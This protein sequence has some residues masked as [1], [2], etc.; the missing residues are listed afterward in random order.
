MQ[1]RCPS[2]HSRTSAIFVGFTGRIGAGKTS[3]AKYLSSQYGFQYVRYSQILQKWLSPGPVDRDNLRKLGSDVMAGGQQLELNRRLI[4]E[5]DPNRSAAI[6]GVRHPIDFE[7]LSDVFGDSFRLIFLE[8]R[9]EVR[10]DRLRSRFS[11]LT[12]FRAA[13]SAPVEAH[14]DGL[15]AQAKAAIVNEESLEQLY[16]G[17]N[18]WVA[19]C[20]TEDQE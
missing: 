13:D 3:A 14:I 11:V 16:Q 17:L 9:E 20:E 8:A 1:D 12:A 18:T 7:S 19:A 4:A 15:K 6:D 2:P 5:L 10:F